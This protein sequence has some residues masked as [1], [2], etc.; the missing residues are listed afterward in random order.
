MFP[1]M[2]LDRLSVNPSHYIENKC[3]ITQSETQCE[4]LICLPKFHGVEDL[5]IARCESVQMKVVDLQ[6]VQQIGVH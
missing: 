1:I 4:R 6:V 3:Y 2:P 5:T